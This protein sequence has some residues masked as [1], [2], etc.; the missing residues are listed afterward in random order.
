[1]TQENCLSD[2][3][4]TTSMGLREDSIRIEMLKGTQA[5]MKMELK[6][7]TIQLESSKALGQTI[8]AYEKSFN[9]GTGTEAV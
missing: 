5:R 9:I 8:K 4:E 3:Q 1:V 2:A 7:P 6:S